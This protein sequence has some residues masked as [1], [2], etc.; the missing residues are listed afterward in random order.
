[1]KILYLLP[2]SPIPPNSGNKNLTYNLLKYIEQFADID[3]AIISN[4]SNEEKITIQKLIFKQYK[5]IN[6]IKFYDTNKYFTRIFRKIQFVFRNLHPAYSNYF[7]PRLVRWIK[8]NQD[9]YDLIHFDMALTIPYRKYIKTRPTLLVS[10]DSYSMAAYRAM[11]LTRNLYYKIHLIIQSYFFLYQEKFIY[12]RFSKVVSVS[13]IDT[14]YLQKA[15]PK[16]DIETVGIPISEHYRSKKINHFQKV[17]SGTSS[18]KI[19]VTGSLSHHVIADNVVQILD[20]LKETVH[21]NNNLQL[22]LLGINPHE[23]LKK[24]I[25]QNNFVNHINYVENYSDFLDQDW[26]YLYPQK[27]ASGLQTKLQQAM[28]LGLPIIAHPSSYGGLEA[29]NAFNCFI[30][31]NTSDFLRYTEFLIE[32]PGERFRIGSNGSNY[33][34][35]NFSISSIGR[36][37]LDLYQSLLNSK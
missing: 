9:N 35:S 26:I 16:I 27:S 3:I 7:S 18:P 29:K 37:Y 30:C 25:Q 14:Y 31:K 23:S 4:Y 11:K 24:Y 32:N 36:K 33:I 5:K 10:S 19:L 22:V 20:T 15:N 21:K 34:R 13:D 6:Q 2:Y 8:E 12:H 1:M 17:I 28:S